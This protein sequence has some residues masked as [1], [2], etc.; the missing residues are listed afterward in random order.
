[1]YFKVVR[2]VVEGEINGLVEANGTG[3]ATVLQ[4]IREHIDHTHEQYYELKPNIDYADPL[5]RLG[6]L[7]RHA[8]AN[9]TL[10]E[11]ALKEDPM[12]KTAIADATTRG[13]LSVCSLG[14]GPGIEMLGLTKYLLRQNTTVPDRIDF[15]VVDN[16]T[17][18]AETW[19]Q[20]AKFTE[21][22]LADKLSGGRPAV[23]PMFLEFDVLSPASYENYISMFKDTHI[24]VVN[25]LL[26]ENKASLNV[27]QKTIARLEELVGDGCMFLVIDRHENSTSFVTDVVSMF[28]S[29]FGPVEKRHFKG[30]MDFDEQATDFGSE[31][32]QQLG[33]PRLQFRTDHQGRPTVFWFTAQKLELP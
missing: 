12:L 2:E 4:R 10:F 17:P 21:H 3:G 29:V 27:A 32:I 14:G 20:L 8:G 16:V 22:F 28:E 26:S 9:A 33:H 23:A 31:L 6:Y 13:T 30:P 19:R 1:M 18:W 25:Y 15:T 5:C 7:Y 24:V 11:W